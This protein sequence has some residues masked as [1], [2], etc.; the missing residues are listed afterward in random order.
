MYPATTELLGLQRRLTVCDGVAVPD[1][2]RVSTTGVFAALLMREMLPD[3]APLLCGVKVT[4]TVALCPA[5]MVVGKDSP[6]R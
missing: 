2:D 3:A 5:A 6:A 1:P 4:E